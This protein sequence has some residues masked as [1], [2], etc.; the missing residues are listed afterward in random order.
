MDYFIQFILSFGSYLI[1]AYFLYSI[2]GGKRT[3]SIVALTVILLSTVFEFIKTIASGLDTKVI[4]F[5]FMA[6]VLPVIFAFYV[7]MVITG[8]FTF[9]KFNLKKRKLKGISN[10]IQT[11]KFSNQIAL[12]SILGSLVFGVLITFY[13]D[14]YMKYVIL[15]VLVIA[16]LGSLYIV[17]ENGQ[18]ESEQ[19]ILIIGKNKEFLYRYRIPKTKQKVYVHD[20][21]TQSQYIVDPIGI[22]ILKNPK[23]KISKD[24]L[25]WIATG[26]KI[27]MTESHLEHLSSIS[28][29]AYLEQYE[30]YHYR[31]LTFH[32]SS[33]EKVALIK[34]KRIK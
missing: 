10:T 33:D 4:L 22:A 8:G 15:T 20:F 29:Q 18:I 27:D 21:F 12:Y 17:F 3:V 9:F 30:K 19:V 34:N 13:V 6:R 23:K 32:I 14:G 28:Y 2:L 7:F 1:I 16:L 11:R 31:A 25:F 26:D 24:Y 5:Y